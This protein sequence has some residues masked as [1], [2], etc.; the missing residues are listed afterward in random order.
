MIRPAFPIYIT[1]EP[2]SPHSGRENVNPFIANTAMGHVLGSDSHDRLH[3]SLVQ[4]INFATA[5]RGNIHGKV[6]ILP[7]LSVFFLT[8][9]EKRSILIGCA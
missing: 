2:N 8:K 1:M 6:W 5:K 4:V 3:T 7:R 9:T